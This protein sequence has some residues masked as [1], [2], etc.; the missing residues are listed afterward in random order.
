MKK[1][2]LIL[3]FVFFASS[4]SFASNGDNHPKKD[5][6]NVSADGIEVSVIKE[7]NNKQSTQD[8]LHCKIRCSN[9]NIYSCWFCDCS[10]LPSCGSVQE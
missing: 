9:G 4:M 10:E 1:L 8:A 3:R 5:V 7:V 2:V 6:L